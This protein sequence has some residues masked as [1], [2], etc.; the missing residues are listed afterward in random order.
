ML[1]LFISLLANATPNKPIRLRNQVSAANSPKL[2]SP[3]QHSAVTGLFVIQ[4]R[5]T[6]KAEWRSQLRSLGVQLVKFVPD[7]AFLARL[8]HARLA[9]VQALSYVQFVGEYQA[10]HKIHSKLNGV[11][12]KSAHL[13][14]AV[15]LAPT[16]TDAEAQTVKAHFDHVRQESKLRSGR[17]LRGQIKSSRLDA[18]ARSDFVL[19]IESAPQMK[20]NDEIA[21]KIV[22][23]DGGPNL[24]ETQALGYDGSGVAVA[25]ADSGLNNGDAA[26]MHPDLLGR[27]PAFFFYGTPG[28]LDDAADEHSHGTH[29]S[30]II[31]G[32]GATGEVDDFGNLFGLGVAPGASII[33]QRIF[34]GVGNYAPPPSFE[35]LTRDATRAGAVVGSNSWGDDTQG[36]YDLSAMEFD[37]LVRD[38][39]ALTLGD[40]QY[41][42]EFSAG[43]AGP[44]Q[45]TIGSPACAKNVIATGASQNDRPDFLVYADGI[46][47]MADFSSR[48]PCEDGRI[49]PDVC[50]PGTWIASLQSQ[51]ATDQYAWS[52]I[53][54]NYQYQGGTSQAGPHVSGAA[55]VFVQFFR[56]THTNAT[57]SPALVK[58]ALINSA[59][60]MDDSFG[61]GPT[62]NMDEGWG[63]VDLTQILT[64]GRNFDY[65]DQS[66]LLTNTQITDRKIL[67]RSADAPLIV[68]LAYSD[69]PGFPGAIPAMVNDLDLEVVAPDGSIYRGNQFDD[70]ESRANAPGHDAVNNVEGV[71]ISTPQVGEYTLRV[72]ARGVVDDARGDTAAVD[73]D[74]ALV[75]SAHFAATGASVIALDR[76]HYRAPGTIKITLVDR[77]RAGNPSATVLVRSTTETLG[78][79]Y[80][81]NA[82]GSSGVFT[83][84]VATLTGSAITD[85][86]LQI[87]HG[88]VIEAR[89][90]DAS[91]GSN[92]SAFATA[93]LVAPIITGVSATNEYGYTLIAWTTDEPANSVVRYNTNSTL[94]KTFTNTPLVTDHVVGLSGL[95][96]N[97]T[98]FYHVASTDEAGNTATNNNG[99]AN[100][101]FISPTVSPVLL[102]DAA[103]D[104]LFDVNP[105][106]SG[107]TTPLTQIGLGYDVWA[108]LSRGSPGLTNLLP[109][110]AVIWRCAE[111]PADAN[112]LGLTAGEQNALLDYVRNGGSLFIAS[113]ELLT[114]LEEGGFP[115]ARLGLLHVQN[116]VEDN[117]PNDVPD[118]IGLAN[119]AIGSGI[120]VALDYVEY[121]DPSGIKDLF[122]IPTDVSDTITPD[123]TAEP[124]FFDGDGETIGL[125]YPRTGLDSTGR[126]VFLS[127]PFDAVPTAGTTN[128]R[129]A[130][131][132]NIMEFLI[133][134]FDGRATLTIDQAEYGIPGLVV[135]EVDDADL[136]GAGSLNIT[137]SSTTQTSPTTIALAETGRRGTFRGT[138]ELVPQTNAPAAG[139]LRAQNGDLISVNYTDAS[140]GVTLRASATVDTIPPNI[141]G[142]A[143]DPDYEQAIITWTT[144]EPCDSLVQFGESQ[145]LGKTAYD[146]L[147]TTAH[148]VTLTGLQPDTTN[149]FQVASRDAAGN[150][151]V[152]DNNGNLFTFHTRTPVV[153]PWSDNLNTGATNWSTFDADGSQ[154]SWTLGV[155][156]N[157]VMT[158]AHSPP[159]CWGSNLGGDSLDYAET[160]LISPAIQ[161]TGGNTAKLTFWHSYDFSDQT[162]NDIFQAGTLYIVTGGGS[163]ATALAQYI[164]ANSGWEQEIIDLSPFAGQV[165]YFVW[166][167]QIV[168]FDSAPRPGWLVDDV[169]VTVSNVPPGTVIVTNNIWQANFVLSGPAYQNG[170]G[171]SLKITNAPPGEYILE[172]GDA[173]FY[174]TPANLTNSLVSGGTLTFTGNYTFTDANTNGIPDAYELAYFGNVSPTRTKTTD[175]DGDGA[176]DYAEFVAGSNPTN[177]ASKLRLT[178]TFQP[179][180]NSVK[181]SWPSGAGHGYRV[182]GS[183]NATTW[184]P[185]SAWIRATGLTTTWTV[186]PRTN[187]APYLFRLQALP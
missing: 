144:S 101:N 163:A 184:T 67:V 20:L 3:N 172:F 2:S 62:P 110:R 156:A 82:N 58:A 114:R 14:I 35:K 177:N 121:E 105:P 149:F 132:R 120:N 168:S 109:Y 133:P 153:P 128:N 4:F 111:F 9:D 46:D 36:R 52:P 72:R 100:F 81:L 137:Y 45:Q 63:R 51:S 99:G 75:A 71:Y 145:F 49:K 21:S 6:P 48:G 59:V 30:G 7:D 152:N 85:A 55:A 123:S 50:A 90:A 180:N 124:I 141:T 130:L 107:W 47:T 37:D 127:F 86:K 77:D 108:K 158:S 103:Y 22:A 68:T 134:G 138:I 96:S 98:Y 83:G 159:N 43:N 70:G 170:K 104:D 89:Y 74:F 1:G 60:D 41:I 92:Q 173:P 166:A 122:G 25:V 88:N 119:D 56:A 125:K 57:P 106:L 112:N 187:G 8:D 157:G 116:F 151:V 131:L 78:E 84:S 79:N 129:A 179:L 5:E 42:L 102:V 66:S 95:L 175:T 136:A 26:S 91:T 140:A 87:A 161:L 174:N 34:D 171:T 165:V 182:H 126:V 115:A 167:Y 118:A 15:L 65:V 12:N 39:D 73:Q 33:A 154:S 176:P 169:A 162:Q 54:G 53:S 17:V 11:K 146:P 64:S 150:A 44:G 185:Y 164:D 16:A 23:G 27:T 29:V 181:I 143:A 76:A 19:W 32:N 31:A 13:E 147:L 80:T 24:L 61:T 94:S 155:P 148:E 28:Q 69:V 40:Q 117:E 183:T 135:V 38:A 93:D 186:P 97:K 139:T 18:L 10:Q 160:F 113:M 142:V 178:A